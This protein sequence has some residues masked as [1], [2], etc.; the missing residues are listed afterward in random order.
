MHLYL[1]ICAGRMHAKLA[2]SHAAA[3]AWGRQHFNNQAVL[4]VQER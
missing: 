2:D 4:A 1:L 3:L